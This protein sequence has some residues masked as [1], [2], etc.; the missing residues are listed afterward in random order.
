M[1]LVFFTGFHSE[2]GNEI[3]GDF[4]SWCRSGGGNR[5]DVPIFVCYRTPGIVAGLS[6]R[7]FAAV[8]E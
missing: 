6:Q 7:G 1:A 2:E 4:D 8:F 5:E 3:H